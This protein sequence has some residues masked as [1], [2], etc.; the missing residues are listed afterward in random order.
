MTRMPR[1]A[2]QAGSPSMISTVAMGLADVA[3]PVAP[4]LHN[5]SMLDF[6]KLPYTYT[7]RTIDYAPKMCAGL[8]MFQAMRCP[9]RPAAR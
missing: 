1:S 4:A 9:M 6:Q 8:S 5:L 2:S 7:I 3:V